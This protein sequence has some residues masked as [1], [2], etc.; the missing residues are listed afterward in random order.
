MASIKL[1][2][3]VAI[4]TV[5]SCGADNIG[6]LVPYFTTLSFSEVLVSLLV[7]IILIYIL[8]FT[9]QKN[10]S[11]Y[12]N[13]SGHR[14]VQQMGDC[15]DLYRSRVIYHLYERNDSDIVVIHMTE[16]E[17]ERNLRGFRKFFSTRRRFFIY[18]VF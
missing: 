3:T 6:L 16:C 5:A 18:I 11:H 7:F 15:S 2:R 9:A 1:M 14:K 8:V 12:R 13:R 4:V 17:D 10:C